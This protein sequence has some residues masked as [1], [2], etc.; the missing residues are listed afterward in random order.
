MRLKA[1]EFS[2]D[3]CMSKAESTCP[4]KPASS[5]PIVS[6][7]QRHVD[8]LRT[9]QD[10][11]VAENARLKAQLAEAKAAGSRIRRIPK[12]AAPAPAAPAPAE[13]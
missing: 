1:E 11:L 4:A 6:R 13:A 2:C 9:K 8:L 3:T 7:V 10:K 12:A 5:D